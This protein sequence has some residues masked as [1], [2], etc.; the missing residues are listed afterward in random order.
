MLKT[1]WVRL[2]LTT[3]ILVMTL[4]TFSTSIVAGTEV[5]F[6]ETIEKMA[7]ITE[8]EMETLQKLFLQ[9]QEIEEMEKEA[10][11]IAG[12]IDKIIKEIEGLQRSIADE[13][14][15]YAKKKE[16]LKQ[17]L[18]SYQRIGPGSYL[19][20]VLESKDLTEFLRRINT[21]REITR[22][23]GELLEQLQN[24]K[25]KQATEKM[26]LTEKLV[27]MEDKQA[28]LVESLAKEKQLKK[29]LQND[30]ASLSEERLHY[31]EYL[32]D[33]Q[34]KWDDLKPFF[35]NTA[36]EF[37]RMIEEGSLPQDAFQLS[38]GILGIKGTIGDKKLNEIIAS[39]PQ[40]PEME[41]S[42]HKEKVQ[43]SIPEKNLVLKGNFDIQ[44]GHTLRFQV[45]EG[46]FYGM[47]LQSEAIEELFRKG[48]MM[49]NFKS[50][51]GSFTLR[52]VE[53]KDGYLELSVR[54]E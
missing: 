6:P 39:N 34:Q 24:I 21:L 13:E 20:I 11:G 2:L 36:S 4:V 25:E 48:D 44:E 33:L 9:V 16:N 12:D 31:K 49:I 29:V 10:K 37:S 23:T 14:I 45:T 5:F 54:P 18:K 42:F 22:N 27:S 28:Q 51:L 26:R 32:T 41:F 40:L 17:L 30:L 15:A 7:G 8:M 47:A 19:E 1:S 50:L 35:S 53:L 38:F 46:S 43:L 52:S 3:L